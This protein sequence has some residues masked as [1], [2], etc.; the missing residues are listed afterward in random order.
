MQPR[1]YWQ[2][3]TDTVSVFG[4]CTWAV[5][6][7]CLGSAVMYEFCQRRRQL[8]REGMQR[9][10]EVIDRK[11]LEKRQ[12]AEAVRATRNEARGASRNS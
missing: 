11:K 4:A 9:V 12:Q 8:E 10:V 7:F 2:D 5:G 1:R 3:L 6:T